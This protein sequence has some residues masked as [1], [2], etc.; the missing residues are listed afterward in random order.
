VR[1]GRPWSA[2]EQALAIAREIGDRS[3]EGNAL[4]NSARSTVSALDRRDEATARMTEAEG[5]YRGFAETSGCCEGVSAALG[6]EP[7]RPNRMR[8]YVIAIVIASA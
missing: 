1:L 7:S 3:E 4:Y 6:V 2:I 8:P 5:V